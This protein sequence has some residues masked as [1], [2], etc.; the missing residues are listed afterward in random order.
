MKRAA[1]DR[2][3]ELP[4]AIEELS[5]T[6]RAAMLQA[7][8][9]PAT[10]LIAG[11]YVAPGGGVCPLLAAHRCG[12]R[13]HDGS[14]GVSTFA[15]VWD[16]YTGASASEPRPIEQAERQMLEGLL[17]AS[18]AREQHRREAAE[19]RE[20]REREAR[21]AIARVR[22]GRGARLEALLSAQ[23]DENRARELARRAGWAWLGVYRRYD[24]YRAA[25]AQALNAES[26]QAH[27][28]SVERADAELVA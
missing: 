27:T 3:E 2:A 5:V 24:E 9:C 14:T 17:V 10:R 4:Q 22:A 23:G 6:T 21:G 18:L 8:R 12:G 28:V 26:R 16:R 11:S 20:R 19:R 13:T 7:V 1:K 25:V 15:D